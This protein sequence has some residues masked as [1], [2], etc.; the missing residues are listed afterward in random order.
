M[1]KAIGCLVLALILNHSSISQKHMVA[2][3]KAPRIKLFAE[4]PGVYE[5]VTRVNQLQVEGGDTVEIIVFITGYGEISKYKLYYQPSATFFDTSSSRIIAALEMTSDKKSARWGRSE[6]KLKGVF[7]L[8]MGLP[9]IQFPKW[10]DSTIFYDVDTNAAYYTIITETP[11]FLDS[12]IEHRNAY[13]KSTME[14]IG[15]F[16]SF[17]ITFRLVAKK[18][19]D[20]GIYEFNLFFTYYNGQEWKMSKSSTSILYKNVIQRWEISF[21]VLGIA[22]IL[23]VFISL[24]KDVR[25]FVLWCKNKTNPPQLMTVQPVVDP[26]A[27]IIQKLVIEIAEKKE[28]KSPG[29][30]KKRKH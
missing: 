10:K 11:T 22:G 7:G 14:K 12:F 5:L 3:E 30:I 17:P 4:K 8:A 1:K 18:N 23:A 21:W 26:P 19:I 6:R 20:P 13:G 2:P 29:F 25:T 16:V 24:F 9:W 27:P 28:P 15:S